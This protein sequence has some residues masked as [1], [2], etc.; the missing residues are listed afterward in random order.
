MS[1]QVENAVDVDADAFH[2]AVPLSL[3]IIFST[4]FPEQVDDLAEVLRLITAGEAHE[5]NPFSLS[6]NPKRARAIAA[7]AIAAF[8]AA[9]AA[10]SFSMALLDVV[11]AYRAGRAAAG[12]PI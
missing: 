5:Q 8:V 7:T 10:F 11:R 12:A 1:I 4:H 3:P 6:S 9:C 2:F